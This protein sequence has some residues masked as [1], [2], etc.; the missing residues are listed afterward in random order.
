MKK[1]VGY[2]MGFRISVWAL[3]CGGTLP[4][5]AAIGQPSDA[6]LY[7][8]RTTS[9]D[10]NAVRV[11]TCGAVRLMKGPAWVRLV[12]QE[13]QIKLQHHGPSSAVKARF[14][15]RNEGPATT[16]LIGFPEEGYHAQDY[17]FI[18]PA[19]Y[20]TYFSASRYLV[21]GKPVSF[22]RFRPKTQPNYGYRIWWVSR[23]RFAKGQTRVV[24]NHYHGHSG[25]SSW[26]TYK[27]WFDYILTT[28][29]SWQGPIG[30]TRIVCNIAGLRQY[31]F[32]NLH[33]EPAGYKRTA[34]DVIW[35]FHNREPLKNIHV[36]WFPGFMDVEVN[37]QPIWHEGWRDEWG[38]IYAWLTD[39]K[40]VQLSLRTAAA[41]LG[42][43]LTVLAPNQKMRLSRGK[44]W[45]DVT[46][47][48][49][50]LRGRNG[51]MR[52]PWPAN[53]S[54]DYTMVTLIPIV[55]I[56]GGKAHFDPERDKMM[57]WLKPVN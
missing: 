22:A 32:S 1:G 6:Q 10:P 56:L 19:T 50:W 30:S 36:Q 26:R 25:Q 53:I 35:T 48:S 27:D 3:I 24:A 37:R 45:V 23:V 57:V 9:Y 41:W 2:F 46:I 54:N 4:G 18:I 43:K 7:V 40:D 17:E 14:V 29:A 52:L 28:G 51:Q 13:I 5:Q 16:V 11:G 55:K 42:A 12:S 15:L 21:D 38:V 20:K 39:D 8:Q 49:P 31:K 44:E 33:F 34:N 47:G